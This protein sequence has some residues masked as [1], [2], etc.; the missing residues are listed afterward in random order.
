MIRTAPRYDRSQIF[1]SQIYGESTPSGV[2]SNGVSNQ[3]RS[4]L[5]AESDQTGSQDK[6]GP[7]TNG[8]PSSK[9]SPA[10]FLQNFCRVKTCAESRH[11]RRIDMDIDPTRYTPTARLLRC[12]G[13][14]TACCAR[15]TYDLL[16]AEG[17]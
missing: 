12:K 15:R 4:Q 3:K 17:V 9:P 1:G 16:S 8:T 2:R 10:N 14:P 13:H 11:Y 5:K 7:K 6:R